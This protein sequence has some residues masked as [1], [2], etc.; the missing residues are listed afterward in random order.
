VSAQRQALILGLLAV[1]CWS[2]VATAF[3]LTLAYLSPLQLM[4]FASLASWFFLFIVVLVQ[5]RAGEL[6]RQTNIV[7]AKSFLFGLLNPVVYYWLLFS[8][9]DRLPAQ[10]AQAINYS[11]A[12]VMSLLAVPLL[13]QKLTR[14]DVIA[15]VFCYLGVLVIATRGDLLSLD[16]ANIGGVLLALASTLIWSLYWIYG[17]RD[18][19]EPMLG[20]YL[21]FSFA[22]PILLLVC[23]WR[24]ELLSI[25]LVWQGVI[26][27]VYIGLF[28]MG[29]GFALWLLAMKRA[30]KTAPVANLIFL[31]PFLSLIFISAVLK[32]AILPSTLIALSLI[33]LGLVVQQVGNKQA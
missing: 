31:S 32:E 11:W 33:M 26:G 12:I 13:G 9:Y 5:G 10:E 29:L 22:V 21:N 19:R 3:K 18:Q 24:N 27:G 15:A 2:T 7:Y 1:L 30:E 28:E 6:L 4:L 23:W 8:A 16:F 14:F 17:R 25:S 20:L